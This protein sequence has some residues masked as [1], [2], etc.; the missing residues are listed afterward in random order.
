MYD[1]LVTYHLH[2]HTLPAQDTPA[3]AARVAPA[4]QY[5][6]AGN[7]VFVQATTRFFTAR[8]CIAPGVVRGLPP[9]QPQFRLK[10]P[11][12]PAGLLHPLLAD[13]RGAPRPG[14]G[15]HEALYQFHHHGRTVQLKKPPQQAG[16]G[17]VLAAGSSDPAILC[18]LHSH[19]LLPAYWSAT[20]DADEQGARLYAV[21]GRLAAR[22]EIR[23]RVGVYGYWQ[24]LPVTAAFTGRGPF[25]DAY[26][27]RVP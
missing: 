17:H 11:C 10:V 13:A 6:L 23:L 21:I 16:A 25:T 27:E 19:G 2:R 7:G 18:E 4:Y 26:E 24:P 12:L 8:L 14:C 3:S 1:N 15:L 9:L 22:P 5:I 20:D